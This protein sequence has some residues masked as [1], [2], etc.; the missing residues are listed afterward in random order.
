[1]QYPTNAMFPTLLQ[2]S[3]LAIQQM[4]PQ[5]V[6]AVLT[7]ARALQRAAH[8]RAPLPLLRGKNIA[9]M[10]EA[11]DGAAALFRRSMTELGAQVAHVRPSLSELSTP[12]EVGHAARML[13]QLY[14][15]VECQGMPP[16]L[17]QQVAD[18]AGVP[19]FDGIGSPDHPVALL[20]DQLG[21]DGSP[22]DHRRF[23]VQAVLL[24]ALR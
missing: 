8:A 12:A 17:V 22:E 11:D 20:A 6:T 1:M 19:V 10:C 23:V 13:G 7:H 18:A 9:L 3:R 24:G 21:G 2:H 5:Q 16:A 14:D 4:S 15:A